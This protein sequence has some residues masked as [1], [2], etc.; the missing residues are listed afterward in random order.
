MS[1][2]T[3]L[4]YFTSQL[5]TIFKKITQNHFPLYFKATFSFH[6]VLINVQVNKPFTGAG[7]TAPPPSAGNIASQD[8]SIFDEY[9]PPSAPAQN[10]VIP[11]DLYPHSDLYLH[12]YSQ[13]LTLG[14]HFSPTEFLSLFFKA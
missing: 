9:A 5:L 13:G 2:W 12:L 6:V 7:F 4:F 10:Q 14:Q 3:G 11:S 8:L 1:V